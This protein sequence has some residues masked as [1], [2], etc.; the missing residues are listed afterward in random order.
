MTL[1]TLTQYNSSTQQWSTSARFNCIYRPGSDLYIVYDEVR[2]DTLGLAEFRDHQII[3]TF[4][5][6]SSR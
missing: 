2:R 4:T 3:V 6:L 1:R 5:Y